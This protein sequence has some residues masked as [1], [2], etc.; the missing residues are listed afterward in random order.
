MIRFAPMPECKN[1]CLWFVESSVPPARLKYFS[2]LATLLG[3]ADLTQD[4]L[5]GQTYLTTRETGWNSDEGH[6]RLSHV[7]WN[8][9]TLDRISRE[10][11]R[12]SD[13]VG[14]CLENVFNLVDLKRTLEGTHQG[15]D[16]C[17]IGD[18]SSP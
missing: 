5:N 16:F 9:F 15:H 1:P 3:F 10:L 17:S 7:F 18:T 12:C 8:V 11:G 4:A 2:L 6:C 13:I 14:E